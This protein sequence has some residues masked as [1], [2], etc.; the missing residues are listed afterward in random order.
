ME[1]YIMDFLLDEGVKQE[2]PMVI[3]KNIDHIQP[4]NWK[5]DFNQ[6]D[7]EDI[8]N[9]PF[10]CILEHIFN[11]LPPKDLLNASLVCKNWYNLIGKLETF[12]RIKLCF[13]TNEYDPKSDEYF[14]AIQDST[15]IYEHIDITI[16]NHEKDIKIA[17]QIIIKYSSFLKSLKLTKF[18]G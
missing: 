2:M 9:D 5:L 14:R 4:E 6:K 18:G 7:V 17:E 12:N 10:C 15:R 11:K 16:W 8:R 13:S 3:D 1:D